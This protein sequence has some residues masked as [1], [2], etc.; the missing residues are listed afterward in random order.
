MRAA[1]GLLLGVFL[2]T[3]VAIAEPDHTGSDPDVNHEFTGG[4]PDRECTVYWYPGDL[5][6]EVGRFI[7]LGYDITVGGDLSYANISNYDVLF[8]VGTGPGVIGA[9]PTM[10]GLTYVDLPGRFDEIHTDDLGAGYTLIAEGAAGCE[11]DVHCAGGLYGDGVVF[12]DCSNMGVN[13][14][15]PGSDQYC[16]NVV[17]WLCTAG[18]TAAEQTTWGAIKSHFK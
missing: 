4:Y 9:Y 7:G 8:I 3:G 11:G 1:I 17:E 5:W 14:A 15:D 18:G 13:S 2:V 6:N 10:A 12:M 16:I